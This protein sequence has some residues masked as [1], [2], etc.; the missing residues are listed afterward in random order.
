MLILDKGY[1]N[2][3]GICY[4]CVS[5]VSLETHHIIPVSYG[6]KNG[7]LVDLCSNCHSFIHRMAV[8]N[9]LSN[10]NKADVL[11]KAII[12]SANKAKSSKTKTSA[13]STRFSSETNA[14]IKKLASLFNTNKQNIVVT[15]INQ[16]YS[17]YF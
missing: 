13:F 11:I 10:N 3:I 9:K 17:K 14:K 6:G 15:A 4:I 12:Q 1:H 7:P 2:S 5:K 8:T 16:L